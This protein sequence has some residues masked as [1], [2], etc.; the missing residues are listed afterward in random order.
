[1][2]IR[3]TG[4]PSLLSAWGPAQDMLAQLLAQLPAL[5]RAD[6]P[7]RPRWE[8]ASPCAFDHRT[9]SAW[10]IGA[11]VANQVSFVLVSVLANTNGGN[12]SSFMYAYTFM[13]L[14]YA[15]IAV[16]IAYAVAPDLAQLWTDKKI[17]LLPAP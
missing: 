4:P 9:A 11:V 10:T 15:I 5:F 2:L 13:Q 12:L 3:P 17:R 8:P 16:S 6:I 7:L 14:P 1:M